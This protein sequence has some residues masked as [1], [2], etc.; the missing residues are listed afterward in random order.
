MRDT[1]WRELIRK[2]RKSLPIDTPV[3]IRRVKLKADAGLTIFDGAKYVIKI[4]SNQSFGVQIDSL[5]HEWAHALAM[6]EAYRHKANW[7]IHYAK[8]YES[9]EQNFPTP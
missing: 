6:E 4:A 7:G 3:S 5:L 2:L 9:W 8:V 1:E